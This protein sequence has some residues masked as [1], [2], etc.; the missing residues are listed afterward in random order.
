MRM[1]RVSFAAI[2]GAVAL[3]TND[4]AAPTESP[5]TVAEH[6]RDSALEHA[7]QT[8]HSV[9]R[10]AQESSHLAD[11]EDLVDQE[12]ATIETAVPNTTQHYARQRLQM[13]HERQHASRQNCS[14]QLHAAKTAANA[15][16]HDARLLEAARRHAGLSERVYE[17]GFQHDEGQSEGWHD[18]A[19]NY[20]D[21]CEDHIEAFFEAVEGKIEEHA[22]HDQQDNQQDDQQGDQQG[23][24]GGWQHY[25]PGGVSQYIPGDAPTTAP[26]QQGDQQGDQ[27]DDR[28]DSDAPAPAP[29]PAP[30]DQED[31]ASFALNLRAVAQSPRNAGQGLLLTFA[32]IGF[33]ASM[34]FAVQMQSRRT[35]SPARE[36]LLWVHD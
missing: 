1:F 21:A 2:L 19:E 8:L 5:V 18:E 16:K 26:D 34:A 10:T 28:H 22:D 29:A 32:C 36:P 6:A 3:A 12:V 13:M 9:M 14:V 23:G 11:D 24:A 7:N 33:L 35:R 15:Y 4:T 20:G 31:V 27:Q 25:I 17:G 30:N